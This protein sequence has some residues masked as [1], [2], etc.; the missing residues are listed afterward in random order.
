MKTD[1]HKSEV[2]LKDKVLSSLAYFIVLPA[3]FII[4][5]DRRKKSFLAFHAAQV[6]VYWSFVSFTYFLVKILVV[7]LLSNVNIP[8]LSYLPS[9]VFYIA[10]AYSFYCAFLAISSG[11]FKIPYLG[12]IA[13][14][15]V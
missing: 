10:W 6:L 3:F 4:L 12:E 1:L 9:M 7:S 5:T 14:R 15:L 8:L 11:A 13:E 2:T